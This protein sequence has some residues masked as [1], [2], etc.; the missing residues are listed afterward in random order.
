M[1]RA[2]STA[3]PK[4]TSASSN[5]AAAKKDTGNERVVFHSTEKFQRSLRIYKGYRTKDGEQRDW[6]TLEYAD[7]S[8]LEE[9]PTMGRTTPG[10]M[11]ILSK[12]ED[13]VRYLKEH[14]KCEG[15]PNRKG[16]PEFRVVD[17]AAE[18]TEQLKTEERITR[19]K[20]IVFN[21][22]EEDLLDFGA[23]IRRVSLSPDEVK[24]TALKMIDEDIN[25]FMEM[26]DSKGTLID[27]YRAQ[28]LYY[29]ALDPR[30][31][32]VEWRKD[33]SYFGDTK[34]GSGHE[35]AIKSLTEAAMSGVRTAIE[36]E[37]KKKMTS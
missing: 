4:R 22:E 23:A 29:K 13:L 5:T 3:T 12:H 8:L 18:R 11:I 37:I 24:Q 9:P 28:A 16:E 27:F 15:S 32:V 7:G 1:P 6:K 36:D 25:Q 2:K 33:G 20:S 10:R 31:R 34:L 17:Q 35:Q 21:M 19:A 14:P 30:Y 26:F